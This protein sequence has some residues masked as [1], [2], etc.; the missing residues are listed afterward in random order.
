MVIPKNGLQTTCVQL[1]PSIPRPF[2]WTL[3]TAKNLLVPTPGSEGLMSVAA[4]YLLKN[5]LSVYVIYNTDVSFDKDVQI[6]FT[7]I[8]LYLFYFL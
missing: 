6:T 1:D 2:N 5:P 3:N 8:V 7:E 4:S